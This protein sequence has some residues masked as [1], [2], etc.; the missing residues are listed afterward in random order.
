MVGE[1][2][3]IRKRTARATWKRKKLA[4]HGHGYLSGADKIVDGKSWREKQEKQEKQEE[5]GMM[6]EEGVE[7]G[8]FY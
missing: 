1:L 7:P 8:W 4:G 5:E 6:G 2:L 3:Q